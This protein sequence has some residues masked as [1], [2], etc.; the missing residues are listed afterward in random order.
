[1]GQRIEHPHVVGLYFKYNVPGCRWPRLC[2]PGGLWEEKTPRST[3]LGTIRGRILSRGCAWGLPG[4][5]QVSSS[6][7]PLLACPAPGQLCP[8]R[9]AR[10]GGGGGSDGACGQWLGTTLALG[11]LGC[12][13]R[14]VLWHPVQ[15]RA[16]AEAPVCGAV[17]GW[18]GAAARPRSQGPPSPGWVPPGG[19]GGALSQRD[20]LIPQPRLGSGSQSQQPQ[21][22]CHGRGPCLAWQ[23]GQRAEPRWGPG[24]PSPPGFSAFSFGN[25][26]F[27]PRKQTRL[28]QWIL[29]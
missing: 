4:A 10:D 7:A 19:H 27:R 5:G 22:R 29:F 8:T 26:Q 15:Q 18:W 14:L 9:A 23:S 6:S 3:H 20:F 11:A 21:H 28:C 2:F 25:C 24:P 16:G 12:S 17:A 1:M 13:V